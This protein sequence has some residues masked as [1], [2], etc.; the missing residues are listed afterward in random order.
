MMFKINKSMA[1]ALTALSVLPVM[2]VNC[3][4]NGIA[5]TDQYSEKA[6]SGSSLGTDSSIVQA[7]PV[8]SGDNSSSDVPVIN[9]TEPAVSAAAAASEDPATS[10]DAA[11]SSDGVNVVN[12]G[13]ASGSSGHTCGGSQNGTD[14]GNSSRDVASSNG[15]NSDAS[16][17][18]LVTDSYAYCNDLAAKADQ[19]KP[20]TDNHLNNAD[21]SFLIKVSD[22]FMANNVEGVMLIPQVSSLKIANVK[23][24]TCVKA[25][26]VQHVAYYQGKLHI[27]GNVDMISNFRGHLIVEGNINKLVNFIGQLEVTGQV[28]Q[29]VRVIVT[30]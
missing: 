26:L 20:I 10:S 17:D 21:G 19:L 23:G 7:T 3:A 24:L 16:A 30:P 11:P 28:K 8:A 14:K 1:I 6:A 25:D 13:S 27:K 2:F 18:V 29:K 15:K 12:P 9:S 5:L 4:K 22:Q